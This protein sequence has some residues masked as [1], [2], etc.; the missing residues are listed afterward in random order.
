MENPFRRK[1]VTLLHLELLTAAS[2]L[3]LRTR[4]KDARS[5]QDNRTRFAEYKQTHT[6]DHAFA[7]GH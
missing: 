2:Y 5:Q 1:Y 4:K 7:N 3:Q 6:D